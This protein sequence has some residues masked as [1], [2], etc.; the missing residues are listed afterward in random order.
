MDVTPAISDSSG[1]PPCWV[2]C[3]RRRASSESWCGSPRERAQRGTLGPRVR[4]ARE[5]RDAR[6]E[7]STSPK[8]AKIALGPQAGAGAGLAAGAGGQGA[9]AEP[10]ARLGRLRERPGSPCGTPGMRTE[11]RARKLHAQRVAGLGSVPATTDE[12]A[13]RQAAGRVQ[14]AEPA[15]YSSEVPSGFGLQP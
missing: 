3:F 15:P 7:T 11:A 12:A 6:R 5:R 1:R 10:A 14:L 13:E 9:R 8:S 2:C 4:H